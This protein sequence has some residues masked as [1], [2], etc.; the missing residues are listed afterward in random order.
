MLMR[1]IKR[2][3]YAPVSTLILSIF[4]L[5]ST[6]GDI[7]QQGFEKKKTKLLAPYT[8]GEYR[9]ATTWDSIS[10]VDT[11]NLVFIMCSTSV[12]TQLLSSARCCV[13]SVL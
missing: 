1:R 5:P 4:D 10:L 12:T 3:Y 2:L 6:V 9:H 13:G 7:T 8:S 11:V